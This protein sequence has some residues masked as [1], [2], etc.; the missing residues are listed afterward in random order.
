[1][2]KALVFGTKDCRFESCQGHSCLCS[3]NGSSAKFS[4]ARAPR[5][6]H[7]AP[8]PVDIC[9]VVVP[10]A[11][12]SESSKASPLTQQKHDTTG[13]VRDY[14]KRGGQPCQGTCGLVAMTSASHAEGRQFD[15]GQVYALSNKDANSWS[16]VPWQKHPPLSLSIGDLP[17]TGSR[18]SVAS[19]GSRHLW[20]SGY[21]VSLTR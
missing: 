12:G 17:E 16:S 7:Y 15:P 4:F 9:I 11:G 10:L 13:G 21:D 6:R 19:S 2:D 20:S 18:C 5:W 8:R 14:K 1:M 3:S